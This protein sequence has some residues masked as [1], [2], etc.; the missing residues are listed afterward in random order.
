M[1]PPDPAGSHSVAC[2]SSASS[3][4]IHAPPHPTPPMNTC[5]CR[6]QKRSMY[7][8][9]KFTWTLIHAPAHPTHG[10]SI[11]SSPLAPQKRKRLASKPSGH[12]T[13]TFYNWPQFHQRRKAVDISPDSLS[14]TVLAIQS[15]HFLILVNCSYGMESRSQHSLSHTSKS[16]TKFYFMERLPRRRFMHEHPSV[17][18]NWKHWHRKLLYLPEVWNMCVMRWI[19]TE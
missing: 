11:T 9:C 18:I 12:N 3:P 6:Q 16:S 2:P 13:C 15:H 10:S 17:I 14:R 4:L 7:F 19:P 5:T 8:I 1:H